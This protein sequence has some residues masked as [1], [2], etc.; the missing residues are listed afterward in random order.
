M[1]VYYSLE[2]FNALPNAIVTTGTFDGVHVGHKKI[3]DQLNSIASQNNG[4]SVLLTFFP[5]P[6][7]VLQPELELKL[8]NHQSEK[9]EL[10]KKTGLDHLIIHPFTKEF[11]RTSSLDFVR[12]ILVSKIGAKK[13][14]IGYDHHFGRN[15]EGSFE[16]LKE[17]GPVYGFDVE[18]IPAQD[19][20]DITISSTKIRNAIA[21]GNID[22]AANYLGYKYRINGKVVEGQKIGKSLGFPTANILV[23]E[24]YKLIPKDGVYAVRLNISS[25]TETSYGGMCNI[26]V[27]PTFGQNFKTI[28]VNLFNFN[29]D[30]YGE[31]IRLSFHK[32]IRDEV[33]FE[34]LEALKE[35]LKEDQKRAY[36]IL[37]ID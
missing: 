37:D 6:R 27:R 31:R 4:E 12:N 2:D 15:R 36:E 14:V 13:L 34:N 18:E 30:I 28:E 20:E 32:R 5:H 25:K 3:L 29:Q 11:S 26:G 17:F 24:N 10:L 9:I 1:K 8:L 23:D 33:K 19:I 22:A 16:H 35:Q 7:M 21:E